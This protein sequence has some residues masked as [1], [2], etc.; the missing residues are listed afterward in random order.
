MSY[1]VV[2]EFSEF[3]EWDSYKNH[4][5]G[6]FLDFEE[7]LSETCDDVLSCKFVSTDEDTWYIEIEFESEQ[8]Y[9]W[10]LLKQ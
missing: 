9:Q 10:F 8:H 4:M 3:E 1:S 7:F 2:V 5:Y 6:D